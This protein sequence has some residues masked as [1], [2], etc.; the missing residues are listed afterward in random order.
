MLLMICSW[1]VI[2]KM[3][4]PWIT[5]FV[6][7]NDREHMEFCIS[8]VSTT[9]YQSVLSGFIGVG[10]LPKVECCGGGS[11]HRNRVFR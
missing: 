8:S 11:T 4:V 2:I 3:G 10:L 6:V 9:F 5:D 7:V 1:H